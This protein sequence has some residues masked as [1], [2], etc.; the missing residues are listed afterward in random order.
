MR[1]NLRLAAANQSI[2]KAPELQHPFADH[3]LVISAVVVAWQR[4]PAAGV[5]RRSPGSERK[6]SGAPPTTP[7]A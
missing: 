6:D 4:A 5:R 1:W 7:P 2:W 3:G